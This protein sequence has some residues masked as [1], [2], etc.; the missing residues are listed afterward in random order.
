MVRRREGAFML[1]KFKRLLEMRRRSMPGQP[2]RSAPLSG[3][4]FRLMY[5]PLTV[6]ILQARNRQWI[7]RYTDEFKKRGDLRPIV[8]FPDTNRVYESGDLWPFFG[9]R[10]PSLKQPSVRATL[11]RE[12]IDDKDQ[13][14]L[15]RRFGRR[16]VSN[17]FVL[18]EG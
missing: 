1:S 2:I 11:D 13:V 6:G 3:A 17:P 7:F 5:G 10:I 12:H 14:Q 15:L 8:Q 18:V 16:T 4:E 9:L